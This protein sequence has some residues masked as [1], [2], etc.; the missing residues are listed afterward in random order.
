M[1]T[2]FTR[3]WLRLNWN[4]RQ[5]Q[6]AIEEAD[7]MCEC[8]N[9][10]AA[11]RLRS[12]ARARCENASRFSNVLSERNYQPAP[13]AHT[14]DALL[15]QHFPEQTVLSACSNMISTI[16]IIINVCA[17]PVALS[18]GIGNSWCDTLG[19]GM[20]C[21]PQKVIPW[22]RWRGKPARRHGA[23]QVRRRFYFVCDAPSHSALN[24]TSTCYHAALIN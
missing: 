14:N 8:Q 11:L 5:M 9:Q 12:A 17:P 7:G 18:R 19:R 20:K 15:F 3:P 6:F 21:L 24:C 4:R 2:Q 16:L 13:I 1:S 10:V 23:T 22:S